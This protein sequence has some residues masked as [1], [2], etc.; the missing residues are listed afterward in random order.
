VLCSTPGVNDKKRARAIIRNLTAEERMAV[1]AGIEALSYLLD[2]VFLEE[3]REK[4]SRARE[5]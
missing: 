3:Q 2:D 4:R 1:R 5:V